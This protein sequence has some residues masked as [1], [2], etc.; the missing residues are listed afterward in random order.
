MVQTLKGPPKVLLQHRSYITGESVTLIRSR[1]C[2]AT[3]YSIH[4]IVCVILIL[5]L[6]NLHGALRIDKAVLT[7]YRTLRTDVI[8]ECYGFPGLFVPKA[9]DFK[10]FDGVPLVLQMAVILNH[11]EN[12]LKIDYNCPPPESLLGVQLAGQCGMIPCVLIQLR[13]P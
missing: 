3:K 5:F 4:V 1:S 7:G 8:R 13:T 11:E 10:F 2:S 12:S 6:Y 9:A